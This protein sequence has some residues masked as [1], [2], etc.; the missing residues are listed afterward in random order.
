MIITYQTSE[1]DLLEEAAA[2]AYDLDAGE[3]DRYENPFEQKWTL[4][5][6][7]EPPPAIAKL[8]DHME[9][10]RGVASSLFGGPLERDAYRHYTGLFWYGEGDKLDVHVDAGIHPKTGQRKA[11]TMLV[12]L[13]E[14]AQLDFW[15]GDPCTYPRPIVY[16][17]AAT[18]MPDV[19]T[20]VL[21]DNHD[22]AWHGVPEQLIPGDRLV[23]TVSFLSDH[24]E[25]PG[26]TNERQ[27][28]YFVRRP[29]EWWDAEKYE[30]R[31]RRAD[32]ER[33]AEVY[34]T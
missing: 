30:L 1:L 7:Q 28:A 24:L 16:D 17:L 8:F 13:S 32:P 4:R 12:Y 11:V 10:T 27:R 15:R 22:A 6:K 23:A 29:E 25:L 5:D 9:E 34:R 21:F 3:W 20:V 19:G 26:M 33:Y 14:G 2:A 31:D 18:V